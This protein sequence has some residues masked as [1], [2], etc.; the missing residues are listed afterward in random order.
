KHRIE[1]AQ[2][3]RLAGGG[4]NSSTKGHCSD[5]V[6]VGALRGRVE[7]V[8]SHIVGSFTQAKLVDA[9]CALALTNCRETSSTTLYLW[10]DASIDA[11]ADA[12]A[13]SAPTSSDASTAIATDSSAPLPVEVDAAEQ[14]PTPADAQTT[15]PADAARPRGLRV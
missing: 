9:L 14:Q 15:I 6:D 4:G 5:R 7:P 12:G 3:L 8:A 2:H 10:S 13:S 1:V 11:G